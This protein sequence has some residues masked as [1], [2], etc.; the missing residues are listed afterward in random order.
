[1][2]LVLSRGTFLEVQRLRHHI[3]TVGGSGLN[4]GRGTKIPQATWATK[5]V[6]SENSWLQPSPFSIHSHPLFSLTSSFISVCVCMCTHVHIFHQHFFFFL[7]I[8]ANTNAKHRLFSFLLGCY[9]HSSIWTSLFLLNNLSWRSFHIDRYGIFSHSFYLF[10]F[11]LQQN[12]E[13]F[14]CCC[15]FFFVFTIPQKSCKDYFN[16]NYNRHGVL[17]FVSASCFVLFVLLD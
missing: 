1:M 15:C 14:S 17:H 5:K 11:K 12:S 10:W 6:C 16:Q 3:P 4:S 2:K 13:G 8:Q 9:T 7:Q